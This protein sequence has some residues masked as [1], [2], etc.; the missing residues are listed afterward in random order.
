[1]AVSCYL[2]KITLLEPDPIVFRF[3]ESVQLRYSNLFEKH[4]TVFFSHL[5]RGP[6]PANPLNGPCYMLWDMSC[7]MDSFFFSKKPEYIGQC[8]QLL[9][10]LAESKHPAV[11]E[12]AI[13][14][15]GHLIDDCRDRCQPILERMVSTPGLPQELR[16]Y[17]N[18]A[19]FHYIQ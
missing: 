7:G 13:H 18:K 15:L 11:I 4:C 14:G 17:A 12:S 5:D 8:I 2:S 16:D 3:F 9:D 6:Q 1:M 19:L 10:R